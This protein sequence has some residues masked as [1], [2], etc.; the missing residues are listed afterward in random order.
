MVL[1]WGYFIWTGSIDTIWPLFGVANQLLASVALAVG[2]T[3]IINMGRAKYAWV[4][5][6][7]LCFLAVSDACTAGS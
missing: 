6:L 5:F 7:P 1:A 2:T 3:I 4:T